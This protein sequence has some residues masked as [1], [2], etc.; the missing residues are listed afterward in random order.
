VRMPV[1]RPSALSARAWALLLRLRLNEIGPLATLT[2]LSLSAWAFLAV[3]GEVAEGSTAGIDRRILLALRNPDD[4][5]DP[6]GPLW[7]EEMMRDVTG[8]GGVFVLSY[9]SLGAVAY[10]L[11][12]G[13]RRAAGLVVLAVGGGMLLSEGL[14]QL[15]E[16]PRPDLVPHG[17][18][19]FTASFPSSHAMMS[20][21]TYL[22]L[23][24][25]LARVE[26]RRPV[27]AFIV[28]A[29]IA[30]TLLIGCSRLYLGVHWPSDV[31][32]GWCGGAAWASVCWYAALLLQVKGKV[33]TA[34]A[35]AQA[36][37]G[38]RDSVAPG[39]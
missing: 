36:G 32:A 10:L 30:T 31:F 39:S 15:Y 17:T 20:A 16:R 5:S 26:R 33:E 35:P 11:L 21:A 2:L 19:V 3:A 37:P 22:T 34:T 4:L 25:L 18:H 1:L 12:A 24:A 13:K 9:V 29:G 28:G 7:F 27:K 23:A 14:K 8:L 38:N 6:I